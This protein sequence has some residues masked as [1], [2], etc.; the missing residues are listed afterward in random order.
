MVLFMAMVI[1]C[2]V[3]SLIDISESLSLAVDHT[4]LKWRDVLAHLFENTPIA[5]PV[6]ISYSIN[7]INWIAIWYTTRRKV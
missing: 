3:D 7:A 5:I 6:L 2:R 1:A 4:T